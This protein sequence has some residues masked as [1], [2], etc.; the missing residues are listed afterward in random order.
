MKK[1]KKEKKNEKKEKREK[2]KKKEKER[3]KFFFVNRTTICFARTMKS[4]I[5]LRNL[6]E[7]II[8]ILLFSMSISS[9]RI[10]IFKN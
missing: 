4:E 1:K 8:K 9:T 3:K 10:I 5:R 6:N 7:K 2:K